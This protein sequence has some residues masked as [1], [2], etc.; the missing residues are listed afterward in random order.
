[1]YNGRTGEK[2]HARAMVARILKRVGAFGAER[3]TL[4]SARGRCVRGVSAAPPQ[5][6]LPAWKF[7]FSDV[8]SAPCFA[9]IELHAT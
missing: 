7:D 3:A 2:A 9:T 5:P 8:S 1:M 4:K 6:R